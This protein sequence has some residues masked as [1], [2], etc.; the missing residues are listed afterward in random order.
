MDVN[1]QNP[2]AN[3]SRTKLMKKQY[4]ELVRAAI[5]TAVYIECKN[6]LHCVERRETT[7][8]TIVNTLAHNRKEWMRNGVTTYMYIV[9]VCDQSVYMYQP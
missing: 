8:H 5:Y 9:H 3:A 2:R 4:C 1:K 7:Q 6:S